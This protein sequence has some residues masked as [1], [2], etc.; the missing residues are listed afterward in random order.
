[1][2]LMVFP[3]VRMFDTTSSVVLYQQSWF[4]A[5]LSLFFCKR[6]TDSF[7]EFYLGIFFVPRKFSLE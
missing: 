6:L 1:M 3:T 7:G 5:M 4:L 2:A